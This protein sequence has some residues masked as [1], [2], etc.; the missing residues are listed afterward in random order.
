MKWETFN[1]GFT[2]ASVLGP[3][4]F[5]EVRNSGK[6]T[7]AKRPAK[8]NFNLLLNYSSD[9]WNMLTII[10][11]LVFAVIIIIGLDHFVQEFVKAQTAVLILASIFVIRFLMYSFHFPF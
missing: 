3:W 1:Y 10:T 8:P 9:L 5:A 4:V 6:K 11:L 2:L 7:T